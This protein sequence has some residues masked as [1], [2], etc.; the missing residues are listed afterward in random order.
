M[1]DKKKLALQSSKIELLGRG[2]GKDKDY[3]EREVGA[4][5]KKKDVNVS[6]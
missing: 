6:R 3:V 1:K 2:N 4:F 5:K